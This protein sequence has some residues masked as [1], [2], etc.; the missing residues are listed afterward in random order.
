MEW[1]KEGTCKEK[2]RDCDQ[3]K[4][5][6]KNGVK[7]LSDFVES[8]ITFNPTYKYF[9]MSNE[10]NTSR[11]PAY[12]D[13][14]L[15][16]T[17][18]YNKV[19]T[20]LYKSIDDVLESDHKP[21]KGIFNIQTIEINKEKKQ[22]LESQIKSYEYKLRELVKPEIKISQQEFDV[23]IRPFESKEVTIFIKN[24]GKTKIH[25]DVKDG[26][27]NGTFPEW[28]T[29]TP[30]KLEILRKDTEMKAIR[31]KISLNMLGMEWNLFKDTNS[32]SYTLVADIDNGGKLFIVLSVKLSS[33]SLRKSILELNQ[34]PNGYLNKQPKYFNTLTIPKEVWRLCNVLHHLIPTYNATTEGTILSQPSK[35][36]A[37]YYKYILYFL[38]HHVSFPTDIPTKIYME[39]LLIFL[40]NLK[41][42]IIPSYCY[43]LGLPEKADQI[44]NFFENHR[45]IPTDNINL[46]Y[47]IISFMKHINVNLG[48][49]IQE[50]ATYF[51][52]AFF[53]HS[54]Y[55]QDNMP[56][57][58]Q[59]I[60]T[61]LSKSK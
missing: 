15:Y 54:Q 6:I 25:L 43:Q 4:K 31:V 37:D 53:G 10:Y 28:L 27:L 1:I 51:V 46:F 50:I 58:V 61:F 36:N 16:K 48:N 22:E 38:D 19:D 42:H 60:T 12:C 59:F 30:S 29:V 5:A 24:S 11:K 23:E 35:E 56:S 14:I 18:D 39:F 32:F 49:S 55:T 3:L 2:F 8:E 21:V 45:D 26:Q 17:K 33:T 44:L 13:R 47:Y 41:D 40:S 57:L 52:P 20:Y 7:Y 34:C 9:P